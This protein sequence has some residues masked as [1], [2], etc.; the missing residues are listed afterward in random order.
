MSEQEIL[1]ELIDLV[2]AHY[3]VKVSDVKKSLFL[4][5]IGLQP[6]DLVKLV[7]LIEDKYNF[8]FS[9]SELSMDEFDCLGKLAAIIYTHLHD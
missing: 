7:T 8:R 4:P 3:N 5:E 1:Q 9:E 6:R 2:F